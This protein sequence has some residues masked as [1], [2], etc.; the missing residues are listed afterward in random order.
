MTRRSGKSHSTR[1]S[2]VSFS[3][4]ATDASPLLRITVGAHQFVMVVVSRPNEALHSDM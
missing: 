1:P 4:F 2:D 3:W